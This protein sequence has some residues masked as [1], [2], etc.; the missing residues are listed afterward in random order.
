[1]DVPNIK[2]VKIGLQTLRLLNTPKEKLRLIL[3][4]ANSKAKLDVSEVERTLQV[5]ADALI[6]SDVVVPQA[7]NKGIPVVLASPRSSV[8]KALEDLA[9][10]FLSVDTAKRRR[11]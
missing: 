11:R 6:P 3:N 10:L 5:K 8:S 4:R 2:N 9:N 7:V 1:M